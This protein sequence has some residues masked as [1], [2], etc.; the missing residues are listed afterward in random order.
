MDGDVLP[1]DIEATLGAMRPCLLALARGFR[2][3]SDAE[4][5][6]QEALARALE[7]RDRFRADSDLR[8]WMR[9]VIRNL[10]IDEARERTRL[11]SLD[12]EPPQPAPSA[13][14]APPW[15]GL[16]AE[17]VRRALDG[18]PS[19]LREAFELHYWHMLSLDAIAS[20]LG[21]ARS[22]VGTRLFRARAQLRRA[23]QRDLP[24]SA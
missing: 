3:G 11:C 8:A 22:T 17:H 7:R 4:D 9:P 2:A 19:T 16:D 18:C 21:I 6:V 1:L 10:A 24:T 5:L 13:P 15:A 20:R 23:L 14:D 12:R